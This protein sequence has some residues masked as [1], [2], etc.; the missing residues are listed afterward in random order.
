MPFQNHWASAHVRCSDLPAQVGDPSHPAATA[1]QAHAVTR[2]TALV[3][4]HGL[5][6]NRWSVALLKHQLRSR[7]PNCPCVEY[8]AVHLVMLHLLR[9]G[10]VYLWSPAVPVVAGLVCEGVLHWQSTEQTSAPVAPMGL[11]QP[12]LSSSIILPEDA[13]LLD[14]ANPQLLMGRGDPRTRKGK[15]PVANGCLLTT[16]HMQL[17]ATGSRGLGM[18]CMSPILLS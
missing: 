9:S 17:N 2:I 14:D 13:A 7:C 16:A 5:S 15:V 6:I 10:R 11:Q 18:Q 3:H 1:A 4:V 12:Q 8:Q